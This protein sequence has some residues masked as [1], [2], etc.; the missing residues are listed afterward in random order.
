MPRPNITRFANLAI[1]PTLDDGNPYKIMRCPRITTEEINEIPED[2]L[3]GGEIIYNTDIGDFQLYNENTFNTLGVGKSSVIASFTTTTD[4]SEPSLYIPFDTIIESKGDSIFV[5]TTSPIS[6][7]F[8][9]ASRGSIILKANKNYQIFLQSDCFLGHPDSYIECS[10]YTNNVDSNIDKMVLRVNRLS[11]DDQIKFLNGTY[12]V[13]VN[14]NDLL[15]KIKALDDDPSSQTY[16]MS[17]S[18]TILRIVEL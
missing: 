7:Q 14:E 13:F 6:T 10:P 11:N 16:P 2:G 1:D 18:N 3:K 8:I 4:V 15:M 12:T 5:D 17:I 9:E